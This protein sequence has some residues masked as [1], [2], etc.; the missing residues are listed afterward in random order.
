MKF[1][2]IGASIMTAA[3]AVS[4]LAGCSGS[5]NSNGG[6]TTDGSANTA[7]SADGN[8][9]SCEVTF[10]HAMAGEQEKTLQEITD[11]FNSSNKY[12]IK[13]TLVNQGKYNDLQ[14]KLT[15]SAAS[16]TLPD[17]AQ[18]YNNWLTPYKNKLVKLDDLVKNDFDNWDDVIESYRNECSE[19]GFVHALPFNKSTY[20]LFYNKT[21]FDE[22]KLTAPTTWDE[23]KA[24]AKIVK[25]KKNI[26]FIGFDDMAGAVEATLK[27]NGVD[28]IDDKGALFDTDK[29]LET[30]TFL[31][32][33]Y[34]NGYAR[35]VGEDSFFSNVLSNGKIAA[36]VGSSTGVSYIDTSKGWELGVA[37]LPGNVA[38]AAN[39]AG[40]NL[41]MFSSD[42]NKQKATWEY[43]KFLTS[44]ENTTKWAIKTGYLPVRTSAYKSDEYQKF[45]ADDA[46]ATAS[47]AQADSF[48]VSPTYD[49]S[50]D[51][52]SAVAAKYEELVLNKSD[53]NTWKKELVDTINSQY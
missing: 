1:K 40:T 12:G 42:A 13:V 32:D 6:K 2:K 23:V 45:M 26:E 38:K 15:A 37:P 19:F 11:D 52:R 29:G 34:N 53:A 17:M 43:M 39:T 51:I 14:T 47:Y 50:T 36:Y 25:E 18:A 35:L 5:N 24:D 44:T 9:E 46:T 41:V 49:A 33:L 3:L 31:S 48:F 27:Q 21:M 4:M 16:N 28:Y 10:W 30:F 22:L 7:A 20:V 8:I